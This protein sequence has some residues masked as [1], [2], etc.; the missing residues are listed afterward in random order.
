[1]TLDLEA[2]IRIDIVVEKN[3]Q[4]CPIELKYKTKIVEKEVDVLESFGKEINAKLLK[5]QA[6]LN[7]GRYSFWKDVKRLEM[8]KEYFKPNVI[9]GF[10][11]F[12][13]NDQ[14]YMNS[15]NGSSA[16]FTMK[17]KTLHT[18]EL[19]WKES[20]AKSTKEKCPS[21]LLKVQYTIEE[22]YKTTNQEIDFHYCSVEV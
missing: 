7:I 11:V 9:E 5:N 3:R 2:D 17:A 18:G 1:M 12:M 8:I 20:T 16:D 21:I 13:T 6:A 10:C 19:K 22:W 14:G 15:T 4:F